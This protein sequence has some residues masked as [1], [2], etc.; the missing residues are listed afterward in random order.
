MERHGCDALGGGTHVTT[1]ALLAAL[2]L[3]VEPASAATAPAAVAR[4]AG[5]SAAFA[6][7][8]RPEDLLRG[9]ARAA[10]RFLDAVRIAGPRVDAR[11]R[12]SRPSEAEY[13]KAK[14]LLSPRTHEEIAAR[15]DHPLA[16]WRE[17]ARGRVL[18]WF[19]LLGVRRGPRGTVL[20]LVDERTWL[21]DAPAAPPERIVSEYLVAREGAAWRVAGRRPGGA[22]DDE[23][24]QAVAA[25]FDAPLRQ[26]RRPP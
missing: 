9:P 17:A 12:A 25:A 3:A 8:G 6:S 26:G 2:L 21:A 23:T 7:A 4:D 19:Q 22:F 16:F 15:E 5:A 11:G 1:F 24:A 18:E 14:A 10:L 20:V 13:A